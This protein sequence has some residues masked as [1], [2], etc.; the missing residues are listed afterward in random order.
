MLHVSRKSFPIVLLAC[1]ILSVGSVS[2]QKQLYD[3]Q[4]IPDCD[5]PAS[6]CNSYGYSC[7]S[8]PNAT[9]AYCCGTGGCEAGEHCGNCPL[10]CADVGEVCGDGIDNDCNGFDDCTDPACLGDLSYCPD[11]RPKGDVCLEDSEC[12]SGLCAARGKSGKKCR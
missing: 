5:D 10:D 9:S 8:T 11:C 1:L 12:C 7:T 6:V 3:V 2:A 4:V